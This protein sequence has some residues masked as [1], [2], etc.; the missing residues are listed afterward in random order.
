MLAEAGDW[1]QHLPHP[2]VWVLIAMTWLA[3]LPILAVAGQT[4]VSRGF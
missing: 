4:M 1:L 2:I 3:T